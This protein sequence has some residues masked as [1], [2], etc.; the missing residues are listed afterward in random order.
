MPTLKRKI[1]KQERSPKNFARRITSNKESTGVSVIQRGGD[2][3]HFHSVQETFHWHISPASIRFTGT[4]YT[5]GSSLGWG[6]AR[7][8][9]PGWAFVVFDNANRVVA[10][11]SG[12]P[13][14]WIR[15]NVAIEAWA[16]Y[17]AIMH[18][19][20]GCSY[21][22]D[23]KT[24]VQTFHRG[25]DNIPTRDKSV[26]WLWK[27]IFGAINGEKEAMDVAW[28]P[29]HTKQAH[30]ANVKL[31]NGEIL[32]AA[33]RRGNAMADA[34]AKIAANKHGNV[35]DI[36]SQGQELE[37]AVRTVTIPAIRLRSAAQID[38]VRCKHETKPSHVGSQRKRGRVGAHRA[39]NGPAER[40]SAQASEELHQEFP[41]IRTRRR[42]LRRAVGR[43]A[44]QW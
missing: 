28:I 2:D 34:L 32:T 15:S 3:I 40:Q 25:E 1:R 11:A 44:A 39:W 27:L 12:K 16:L 13:P 38:A 17:M 31:S 23:N 19:T 26:A 42:N 41:R 33:N 35:K 18:A 43:G 14:S 21:R 6:Q 8:A 7:S 22:I 5:D 10:A 20:P 4:V 29:A 9:K 37:R 30:I 36:C 24:C